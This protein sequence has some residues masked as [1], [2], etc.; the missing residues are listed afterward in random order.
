MLLCALSFTSTVATG[1]LPAAALRGQVFMT[2]DEAFALA[3]P[4]ATVE[5]GSAYLTKDEQ[6][7][8]AAL[9]GGKFERGVMHPYVA[10]IDG[11]VIGTAYIDCH[12]VRTLR[13]TVMVVVT[14]ESR[15]ERIEVLSFGE[16]VDYLPRDVWYGQFDGRKLDAELHMK[17]G[18][19]G[20]AGATL[21]ARATTSAARRVL[22]IHQVLAEREPSPEPPRP[23][24]MQDHSGP[25]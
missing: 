12:R 22:A 7:R 17:R 11:K 16:P 3:F 1:S 10:R 13:E 14:P 20:V 4:K 5:R 6:K 18:I 21:T 15:I 24:G 2:L 9:S 19:R 25:Q 8:V 23:V